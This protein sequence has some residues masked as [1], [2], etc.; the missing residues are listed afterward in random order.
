MA[1]LA[2]GGAQDYG[3]TRS[4]GMTDDDYFIVFVVVICAAVATAASPL[5]GFQ[6]LGNVIQSTAAVPRQSMPWSIE[7]DQLRRQCSSI[8]GIIIIDSTGDDDEEDDE[9]ESRRRGANRHFRAICVGIKSFV[10]EGCNENSCVG[11]RPFLMR[12]GCD[13]KAVSKSARS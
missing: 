4:H 1:F 7:I 10:S 8:S 6:A 13:N 2:K 9:R 11:Q 3:D 12:E 5:Q